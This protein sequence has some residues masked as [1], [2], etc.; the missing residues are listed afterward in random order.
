[1][2]P[3]FTLVSRRYFFPCNENLKIRRVDRLVPEMLYFEDK[4]QMEGIEAL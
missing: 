2:V 3:I 1:M 4:K